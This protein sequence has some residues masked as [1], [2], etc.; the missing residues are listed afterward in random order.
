MLNALLGTKLGMT[1]YIHDDGIVSAVTV[2]EVGP[3][4]VTQVKNTLKDGYDKIQIGYKQV[5]EKKM[6]NPEKGHLKKNDL[7][8]FK[9]LREVDSLDSN[10]A[11]IGNVVTIS[12]IF[13][14]GDIV[15]VVGKSKGKGFAGVVKRWHFAGGPKT[16]G[17]GDKWRAPGSVGQGTTPGRVRKGK[18]MGGHLG[19][20]RSTEK[21]IKIVAM[22]EER[23]LLFVRGSVPGA[24]SGLVLVCKQRR[25]GK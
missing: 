23:N 1:Q 18:K 21:G 24:A 9:Y 25:N 15:D 19:D 16:H 3:C 11:Q 7:D 10:D 20:K 2:I 22:D 6:S 17:Q 8:L 14:V 4:V 5:A 13:E 12:Q